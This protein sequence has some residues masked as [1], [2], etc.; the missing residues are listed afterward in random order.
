MAGI[1]P[2]GS[3]GGLKWKAR[4]GV[5][6]MDA[7]GKSIVCDGMNDAGLVVDGLLFPGYAGY[8]SYSSNVDIPYGAVRDNDP[9]GAQFDYTQWTIAADTARGRF[10]FR[11]YNDKNWR[12]VDVKEGGK[13]VREGKPFEKGSS[14]SRALPFPNFLT[15]TGVARTT[16]DHYE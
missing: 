4:P 3:L 13:G 1:L 5:V 8:Q 9:Q 2:D 10:Y 11:T 7:F 12:Y 6:G 14:P 15:I 16:R